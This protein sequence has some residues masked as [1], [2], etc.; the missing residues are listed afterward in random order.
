MESVVIESFRSAFAQFA[1]DPG[2]QRPPDETIENRGSNL[3]DRPPND[4]PRVLL[5]EDN[6]GDARLFREILGE[7]NYGTDVHWEENLTA[8]LGAL[9][10]ET[11]DVIVTD[12]GLPDSE[13]AGTVERLVEAT[14]NLP[15]IVLTGQ[16][17]MQMA[18]ASLEAGATEYLRKDEL[19]PGLVARTLRT[20]VERKRIEA[21][22]R[23][24]ER[25]LRRSRE[26][27]RSLF[28]DSSD[29]ILVHDMEGAGKGGQSEGRVALRVGVRGAGR[30]DGL[31]PPCPWR[32]GDGS[33]GAEG[34]A[35]RGILSHRKPLRAG[36][37][38]GILGG[39][40]RQRHRD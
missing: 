19:L 23:R 5:I 35:C 2:R 11:P 32:R 21:R 37:R 30:P 22:L 1:A 28:R 25:A 7:S 12:L 8:E 31:R 29:A 9:E 6:P 24:Q 40:V 3:M 17:T 36:G 15:V 38:H 33:E 14:G 13:G 20:A 34:P 10:E 27:Y 4:P 26:R 39:G 18:M 16:Q